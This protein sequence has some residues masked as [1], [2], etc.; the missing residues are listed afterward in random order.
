MGRGLQHG[1]GGPGRSDDLH[2]HA[3][4]V[5][6][7]VHEGPSHGRRRPPARG[8]LLAGGQRHGLGALQRPLAL[9]VL[10][11]RHALAAAPRLAA[12]RRRRRRAAARSGGIRKIPTE[13]GSLVQEYG[14]A[15]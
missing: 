15:M 14:N 6:A 3:L 9:L 7:N 8:A 12:P 11:H 13:G 1:E 10:H 4:A 2:D 5:A